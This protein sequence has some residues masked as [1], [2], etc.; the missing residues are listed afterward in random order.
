MR[1]HHPDRVVTAI[2]DRRRVVLDVIRQST[3]TLM[4]SMYR[5][6]D[7]DVLA[8]LADAVTRGVAVDVLVTP[9]AKGGIAAARA[10]KASLERTGA[11]VKN[12]PQPL[13]KYHAKYLV[14][15]DGL[16]IVASLNFTRKCFTQTCD[17]LVLTH[18]PA[19]VSG[20]RALIAADGA[21]RAL[22]CDLGPRL[23]V[24]PERA[25][26]QFMALI[27][28]ARSSVRVIDPK[29][30]DP[31]LLRL[32][33]T[34]RRH[35]LRVEVHRGRRLGHLKSH[36]KLLLIDDRLAVVG[37][38]SLA[39]E[40]LDLRREV[41]LIVDQPAAVAAVRGAVLWAAAPAREKWTN[42][43]DPARWASC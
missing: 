19:V 16:A 29:A 20:L 13:M 5:C 18:D 11:S 25:R 28:S 7:Q 23:I 21:G 4:L 39:V 1:R 32:L 8:A 38:A 17:A 10:L 31:E 41:A 12:F 36:G 42:A 37:S 27:D 15:D 6:D 34:R 33:D 22:P 30:S 24:G 43:T 40:G 2:A 9:R 35:G 14:A 3:R 26:A